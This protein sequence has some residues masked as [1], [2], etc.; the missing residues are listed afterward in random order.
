MLLIP[1]VAEATKGTASGSGYTDFACNAVRGLGPWQLAHSESRGANRGAAAGVFFIDQP[2]GR[3]RPNMTM[4]GGFGTENDTKGFIAGDLR[5]WFGRKLQT[6][7]GV[8]YSSIN[9]DF[10]GVGPNSGL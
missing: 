2:I 5:Y 6:L 1:N 9:L 10:Y 8:I 3:A 4:V 7:T